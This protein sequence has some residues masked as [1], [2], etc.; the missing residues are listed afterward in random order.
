MMKRITNRKRI[1]LYFFML[2]CLFLD[3]CIAGDNGKEGHYSYNV[4]NINGVD[5]DLSE[6]Y[7]YYR[8]DYC[9]D[10][11]IWYGIE[12]FSIADQDTK[13]CMR[14]DEAIQAYDVSDKYI[15]FS[16]RDTIN[17][18]YKMWKYDKIAGSYDMILETGS[19]RIEM[20]AT[21]GDWILYG[22]IWGINLYVCPIEGNIETDSIS[23]RSLLEEENKQKLQIQEG[24]Y[25]VREIHYQGWKVS[26]YKMDREEAEYRIL[27][28]VEEDSKEVIWSAG[29]LYDNSDLAFW[30]KGE[31]IIFT[32]YAR[33]SFYYQ[34]AGETEQHRIE[35][36]DDPKYEN[37]GIDPYCLTME[38][39]CVF[40]L[41]SVH[42]TPRGLFA[43]DQADIENDMLFELNLETNASKI[44][45]E[46]DSAQTRII[47]YKNGLVYLLEDDVIYMG[48]I[49]RPEREK[50]YDLQE[51]GWEL[52]DAEGQHV[53]MDFHWRG[54]NLIIRSGDQTRSIY[55]SNWNKWG[56]KY[57]LFR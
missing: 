56:E 13:E 19:Q 30:G 39:N 29:F 51:E 12:R 37:T 16:T 22:D 53:N 7:V 20:I 41:M 50:I 40:G 36:L 31:W 4:Y 5:W 45:Y 18:S 27:G 10:N 33:K 43:Y 25:Q 11:M 57:V 38:G 54:D 8:K 48:W 42:R 14:S 9:E 21:Y 52:Y 6:D 47:G 2:S 49:D 3:G 35:C 46:T 15:F 26:F 23:L 55:I 1:I 17:D 28:I 32:K 24:F 34:R 44:I